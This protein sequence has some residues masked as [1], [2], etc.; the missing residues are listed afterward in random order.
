MLINTFLNA[1]LNWGLMPAGEIGLFPVRL[2]LNVLYTVILLFAEF[3][4][5]ELWFLYCLSF[6]WDLKNDI[7]C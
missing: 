3:L 2:D 6:Y 4:S 5:I 1:D 7:H